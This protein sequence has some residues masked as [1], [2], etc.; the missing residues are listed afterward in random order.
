MRRMISEMTD[1]PKEV[2]LEISV[3]EDT[4][5]EPVLEYEHFHAPDRLA[6]LYVPI[7]IHRPVQKADHTS[8][9]S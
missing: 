5:N 6:I 8:D 3:H 4:P 1:A 9:E 2:W 7:A